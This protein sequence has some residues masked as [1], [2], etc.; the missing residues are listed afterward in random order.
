MYSNAQE[1]LV[2][3]K[4]VP[5]TFFQIQISPVTNSITQDVPSGTKGHFAHQPRAVTMKL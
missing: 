2:I 1:S 4:K 5:N 3:R